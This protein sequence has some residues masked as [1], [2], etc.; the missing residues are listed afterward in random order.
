MAGGRLAAILDLTIQ[1]SLTAVSVSVK[2]ETVSKSVVSNS[3]RDGVLSDLMC[4]LSGSLDN[5]LDH[6]MVSYSVS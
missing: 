5:R 3:D 1:N 4:D 2:A 6:G